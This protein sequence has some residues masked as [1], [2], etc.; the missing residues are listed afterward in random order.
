MTDIHETLNDRGE[1]YGKFVDHAW[2]AQRLQKALKGRNSK[3]DKLPD[4][5]RQALLTITIK[6]ARI[7]NGDPE[8][9]DNWRDIAGYATL[10]LDRITRENEHKDNHAIHLAAHIKA[11]EEVRARLEAGDRLK[12]EETDYEDL[13]V[14]PNVEKFKRATRKVWTYP[15]HGRED[16][17]DCVTGQFYEPWPE[18]VDIPSDDMLN[19]DSI[20][21]GP[22]DHRKV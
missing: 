16:Q 1:R 18:D 17:P 8:Y 10:I 3:W 12:A 15:Y 21:L 20:F 9:D 19:G 5:S 22:Y 4:D 2:T 6:L 13:D 14:P 11:A 7:V